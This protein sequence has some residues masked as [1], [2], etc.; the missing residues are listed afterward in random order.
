MDFLDFFFLKQYPVLMEAQIQAKPP[1][2]RGPDAVLARRSRGGS[3]GGRW[4]VHRHLLYWMLLFVFIMTEKS[5]SKKEIPS[6]SGPFGRKKSRERKLYDV[7]FFPAW[8]KQCGLCMAFCPKKIIRAD[9]NGMPHISDPDRCTGCRFCEIHC[10][11]FAITVR[12]RV[13]RR[14]R[15]D[16]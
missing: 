12:E 1:G 13:P 11:D 6:A 2:R 8:C 5:S 14:R 9:G 16:E 10:P 15:T 7:V 4:T 3:M